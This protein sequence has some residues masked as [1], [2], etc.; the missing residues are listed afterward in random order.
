MKNIALLDETLKV[1][2][3]EPNYNKAYKENVLMV[4]MWTII[5][6]AGPT[7]GVFYRTL[8]THPFNAIRAFVVIFSYSLPPALNSSVELN[9]ISKIS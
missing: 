7:M 5:S 9:F 2:G 8:R 4:L 3:V 6:I 1:F